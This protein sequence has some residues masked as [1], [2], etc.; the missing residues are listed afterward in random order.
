MKGVRLAGRS[1][2]ACRIAPT[3]SRSS[4]AGVAAGIADFGS[5]SGGA[6][7][8]EP[9][10]RSVGAS[11]PSW[12]G[13]R[14]G[15]AAVGFAGTSWGEEALTS[16]SEA[17]SSSVRLRALSIADIAAETGSVAEF[18]FTIASLHRRRSFKTTGTRAKR[19]PGQAAAEPNALN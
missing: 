4:F 7:E 9:A 3:F 12:V 19:F 17:S 1:F 10:R 14:T 13:L 11:P 15:V 8:G 16:A 6:G 18:C 2:I 5:F